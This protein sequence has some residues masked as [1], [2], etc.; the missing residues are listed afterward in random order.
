MEILAFICIGIAVIINLIYGI[1]LI[2]KAF[3]VSV[4]W[5]AELFICSI[6]GVSFYCRALGN[7]QRSFFEKFDKYSFFD[8][9]CDFVA[10]RYAGAI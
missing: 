4:L 2:I 10:R 7:R 8:R 5:G 6:G 3:Q 9:R 1:A